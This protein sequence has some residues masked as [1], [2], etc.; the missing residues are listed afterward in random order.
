MTL[1]A[2]TGDLCRIMLPM[3][4]KLSSLTFFLLFVFSSLTA[5]SSPTSACRP[6]DSTKKVEASSGI[7][8]GL[9]VH[10]VQPE[11]PDLALRKKVEGEVVLAATIDECGHVA[12]LEPISGPPELRHA[13]MAAVKQWEYKPYFSSGRPVKVATKVLVNFTLSSGDTPL[14]EWKE[15]LYPENSFAITLPSDPHPHKSTQTPNGMAYSVPL[16]SGA[17]FSL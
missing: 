11:Y 15:Y 6:S 2:L 9:L 13:A 10:R 4:L 5:Q 14:P 7:T 8:S 12:E 1:T 16:S 3:L 17:R